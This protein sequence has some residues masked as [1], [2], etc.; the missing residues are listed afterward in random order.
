MGACARTEAYIIFILCPKK[1]KYL[2]MSKWFRFHSVFPL[3]SSIL[4][5]YTQI[6]CATNLEVAY[7]SRTAYFFFF[8]F[9]S[10]WYLI[11]RKQI[12]LSFDFENHDPPINKSAKEESPRIKKAMQTKERKQRISVLYWFFGWIELVFSLQ[13]IYSND[14]E[15]KKKEMKEKFTPRENHTATQRHNDQYYWSERREKKLKKKKTLQKVEPNQESN[16]IEK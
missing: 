11:W 5:N 3:C 15:N 13:W 8:H 12:F 10:T 1:P 6:S 14:S 7:F 9:F 2:R 4:I 16:R